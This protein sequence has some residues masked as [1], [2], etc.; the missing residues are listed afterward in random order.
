MIS[1]LHF[2]LSVSDAAKPG[3]HPRVPGT[4]M[5]PPAGNKQ[6]CEHMR[7]HRGCKAEHNTFVFA[8]PQLSACDAFHLWALICKPFFFVPRDTYFKSGQNQV[9]SISWRMVSSQVNAGA[10]WRLAG[11]KPTG[12]GCLP[13]SQNAAV[14]STC[15][16]FEGW[17]CKQ[18]LLST[19]LRY[20]SWESFLP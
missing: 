10:R 2:F 13:M 19:F 3:E 15:L 17:W 14:S 4:F 6:A 7:G 11:G 1:L 9:S 20:P 16:C 12:N 18:A 8:S 5:S